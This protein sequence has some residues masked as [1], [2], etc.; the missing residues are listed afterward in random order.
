M[1][2]ESELLETFLITALAKALVLKGVLSKEELK[3]S[4]SSLKSDL[5]DKTGR[6]D[7]IIERLK[8]GIDTW[9]DS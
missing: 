4:L 5:S 6:A 2:E 3:T 9:R 8:S 1:S 7:L